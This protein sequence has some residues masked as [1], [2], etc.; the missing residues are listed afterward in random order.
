[1]KNR[2]LTSQFLLSI[3][4][5]LAGLLVWTAGNVAVFYG[6][7]LA[8]RSAPLGMGLILALVIAGVLVCVLALRG[9]SS[10]GLKVAGILVALVAF[11]AGCFEMLGAEMFN[12][13]YLIGAARRVAGRDWKT[14]TRW[15][16]SYLPTSELGW[17]V[18]KSEIPGDVRQTMTISG[19]APDVHIGR[20]KEGAGYYMVLRYIGG[21]FNPRYG[22]ILSN[23][24][25][26][27]LKDA[28]RPRFA[29]SVSP[30]IW[31]Y[32]GG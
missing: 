1:V 32:V 9:G 11:F 12:H 24:N 19:R 30:G 7:G 13:S 17:N 21:G 25:E 3:G 29:R 18:D 5:A 14:T 22:V 15:A 28:F 2:R 20:A 16:E 27:A 8:W 4:L 23:L 26:S 10:V 31:V 6:A